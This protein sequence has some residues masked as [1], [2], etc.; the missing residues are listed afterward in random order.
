MNGLSDIYL[1][2]KTTTAV[3]WDG[4]FPSPF[5]GAGK[6]QDTP[7]DLSV[8]TSPELFLLFYQ[9]YYYYL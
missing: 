5:I 3:G 9:Y 4:I 7:E 2:G 6:G 8:K 1:L